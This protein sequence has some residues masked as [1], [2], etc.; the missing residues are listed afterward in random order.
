M[1]ASGHNLHKTRVLGL[2]ANA[3]CTLKTTDFQFAGQV[4]HYIRE[5]MRIRKMLIR[6]NRSGKNQSMCLLIIDDLERKMAAMPKCTD[7]GA[8]L[9]FLNNSKKIVT[10]LAKN[11][12]YDHYLQQHA[13]LY[14]MATEI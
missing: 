11:T 7:R 8:A 6:T 13:Q 2:Q 12:S 4:F 3:D 14:K 5:V 1:D 9:F 10:L